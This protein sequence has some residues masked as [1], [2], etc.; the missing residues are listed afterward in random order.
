MILYQYRGLISDDARFSYFVDLLKTG[1]LKFSKPS[2]FNDPFDCFPTEVSE[3]PVG[4]IPHFVADQL[5]RGIQNALS[6]YI[7]VSCFTAHPDKMLMWSHYGD[8]HRSI[9]VGFD[10]DELIS[11]VA[12]NDHNCPLCTGFKK[13]EYTN[14]R[15]TSEDN[16]FTYKKSLEW[17]YEDEYRLVSVCSKG[18]PKWGPGVWNIPVSSIK[19]IIL[20]ARMEPG[21][22]EKVINFVRLTRPN[23]ALKKAV[24]H[25]HTFDI[26]IQKLPD[27][28]LC[29]SMSG[30]VHMPNGEW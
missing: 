6:S 28:P 30:V 16:N 20:G 11:S 17:A 25:S 21:L 3:A 7:G 9:C 13:V 10:A 18:A 12:K 15:P 24:I 4:E 19:E 22:E 2:D 29:G 8:Q 1:A 26:L 23:I 14:E 27:M 5:H